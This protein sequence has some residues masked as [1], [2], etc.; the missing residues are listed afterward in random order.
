VTMGRK[1]YLPEDKTFK[2]K[3][4]REVHETRFI[5]HLGSTKMYKYLK[6]FY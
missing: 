4:L 1:I 3:L 2:E 5:V 6:E